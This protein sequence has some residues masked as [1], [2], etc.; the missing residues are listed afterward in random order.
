MALY[1]H[2]RSQTRNQELSS[3]S[4]SSSLHVIRPGTRFCPTPLSCLTLPP[5]SSTSGLVHTAP[6]RQVHRA[7][8]PKVFP[9]WPVHLTSHLGH[10]QGQVSWPQL[11]S[12]LN[13]HLCISHR[14]SLPRSSSSGP[15]PAHPPPRL[16]STVTTPV[17]LDHLC[18]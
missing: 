9:S 6:E 17:I 5:I 13:L 8:L 7:V 18:H 1:W 14:P 16:N 10:P 4:P 12:S 15:L 2:H 11:R 3:T